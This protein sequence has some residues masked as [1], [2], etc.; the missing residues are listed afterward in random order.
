MYS[1]GDAKNKEA[2]AKRLRSKSILMKIAST[3]TIVPSK[4]PSEIK[5]EKS[6]PKKD[7]LKS[8]AKKQ[9][10]DK[11]NIISKFTTKESPAHFDQTNSNT[12][13]VQPNDSFRLL[14]T[15]YQHRIQSTARV[16][17]SIGDGRDKKP[18][19]RFP[20]NFLK[21]NQQ[22]KITK[23][24]TKRNVGSSPMHSIDNMNNPNRNVCMNEVIVKSA[25]V[26]IRKPSL[27]MEN[28]PIRHESLRNTFKNPTN[29]DS[30]NSNKAIGKS[31]VH[32]QTSCLIETFAKSCQTLRQSQIDILNM[33]AILQSLLD[34]IN[35]NVIGYEFTYV[36]FQTAAETL[37]MKYLKI[38]KTKKSSMSIARIVKKIQNLDEISKFDDTILH[39]Y[40]TKELLDVLNWLLND[41]RFEINGT[42][43]SMKI[44]EIMDE[45]DGRE[46]EIL[47]QAVFE[48]I[49]SPQSHHFQQWLYLKNQISAVI[50]CYMFI[51]PTKIYK[52]LRH[53]F[54]KH[55][56]KQYVT[57]ENHIPLLEEETENF[58]IWD[59]K[60][61][62]D[63]DDELIMVGVVHMINDKQYFEETNFQDQIMYRVTNPESLIIKNVLLYSRSRYQTYMRNNPPMIK[64]NS[65]LNMN[66]NVKN[67]FM[68]LAVGVVIG[69]SIVFIFGFGSSSRPEHQEIKHKGEI[70]PEL[71]I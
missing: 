9:D 38:N 34:K 55:C 13:R 25:L 50:Q 5:A 45:I 6:I 21:K 66:I 36:I 57:F 3:K 41:T 56:H 51:S 42:T 27:T 11:R 43:D 4:N 12:R 22:T 15:K 69:F 53:G 68:W 67:L 28:L 2:K 52:Y 60:R 54:S 18:V 62:Q 14:K 35:N 8:K 7:V 47:P 49:Y 65:F 31:T 71:G 10:S 17:T 1:E 16:Q 32:I 63:E 59:L 64:Q 40:E 20:H 70:W 23:P 24:Q 48:I 30:L 46:N 29:K 26:N 58:L 39:Q 44:Y 37:N 33:K 61:T 19:S